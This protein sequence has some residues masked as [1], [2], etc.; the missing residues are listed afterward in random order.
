MTA[1]VPP[2]DDTV[3]PGPG[4]AAR[5]GAYH[6]GDLRAALLHAAE[7]ELAEHGIEAFSLRG[8]ARR[9]GV[10]HAAP[11]HHF[12]DVS[13]LLTALAAEGFRRFLACQD[14]RVAVAG[15]GARDR[16][17]ADGL[18][19]ID[20][21]RAHPALFQLVFASRRPDFMDR[22]LADVAGL[23]YGRLVD[24]V[25]AAAAEVG[26]APTLDDVSA[27]WAVVHGLAELMRTGRLFAPGAGM[28][29]DTDAFAAGII[30]R[31]LPVRS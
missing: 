20:F 30:A 2:V 4:A 15:P 8:V 24:R 25:G 23:A 26:Q 28:P 7:A 11:A 13:G 17:V 1:T 10:S 29:G 21:A 31:C 6:H 5:R 9:A 14:A 16:M 19:Y 12:G 18:G 27:L 3:T 22:D